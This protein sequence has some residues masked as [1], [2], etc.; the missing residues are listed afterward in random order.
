MEIAVVV[1]GAVQW[2]FEPHA[3]EKNV[4]TTP[5]VV[6]YPPV[7]VGAELLCGGEPLG[8]VADVQPAGRNRWH[9][10][11][12]TW[13][14]SDELAL[15]G[16]D[17]AVTTCLRDAGLQ[18]QALYGMTEEELQQI[19]GIGARR[20]RDIRAVLDSYMIPADGDIL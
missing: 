19:D 10:T 5:R 18:V 17:N 16:L 15:L 13:L 1:A 12:D 6:R 20:A 11:Y 7:P 9:I 8:T 3:H 14:A 2:R 4:L